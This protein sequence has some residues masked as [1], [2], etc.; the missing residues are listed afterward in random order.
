M[1]LIQNAPLLTCSLVVEFGYLLGCVNI[2]GF[3]LRVAGV[4]FTGLGVGAG[5]MQLVNLTSLDYL[6]WSFLCIRWD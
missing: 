4:L 6:D 5:Q 1:T 2:F 3:R